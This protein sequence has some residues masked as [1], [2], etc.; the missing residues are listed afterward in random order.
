M[1][2]FE[3]DYLEGAHPKLMQRLMETNFEQTPGYSEDKYCDQAR[4][5]IL[6]ACGNPDA[7]VHFL[8]YFCV[9]S[10]IRFIPKKF[11]TNSIRRNNNGS[12]AK[13]ESIVTIFFCPS[14]FTT[15]SNSYKHN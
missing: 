10:L 8:E 9:V 11:L 4:E 6:A 3:C 15:S 12:I 5:K 7:A 14:G 13:I 2:R 1:I